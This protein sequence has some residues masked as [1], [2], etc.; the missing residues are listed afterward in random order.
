[1]RMEPFESVSIT[2]VLSGLND[3]VGETMEK[4]QRI[5]DVR[6]VGISVFVLLGFKGKNDPLLKSVVFHSPEE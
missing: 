6:V 4:R 2:S 5:H 1:M 3:L